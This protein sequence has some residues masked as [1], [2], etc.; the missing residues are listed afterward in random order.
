MSSNRA[1]YEQVILDHNKAPRNFGVMDNPDLH[2]DGYNALCG[3]QFTVYL[4]MN[5][6]VI[7]DVRFDG[8]G[9]AISKSSASVM[10]TML[11]GK[12]RDEAQALF[13]Q[14]QDM[15]TSD[16][17][18]PLDEDALGKLKVFGGVREYPVRVKCA[19]LA[20]HTLVSALK[21]EDDPVSTE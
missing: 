7:E 12:T 20:W 3:D 11:K 17:D 18:T 15:I 19:T 16:V 21:G 4:K 2:A 10:T 6:D 9:C 8:S 1:L 14:F 5:G 13:A